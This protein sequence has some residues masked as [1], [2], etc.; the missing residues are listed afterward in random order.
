MQP[1]MGFD[2]RPP[3][4]TFRYITGVELEGPEC[5]VRAPPLPLASAV[6]GPDLSLLTGGEGETDDQG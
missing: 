5:R 2:Y 6:E 1:S 4:F 3:R